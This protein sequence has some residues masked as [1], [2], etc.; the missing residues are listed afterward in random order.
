MKTQPET[1]TYTKVVSIV[2][3]DGKAI[4]E[5][6]VMRETTDGD[7]GVVIRIV[8]AGDIGSPILSNVGDLAIS[9]KPGTTRIT[10]RYD[11]WKH[12][13][14]DDQT[15]SERYLSWMNRDFDYDEGQ[16]ISRDTA[17]AIDGI[18]SLLP[19]DIVDWEYGPWPDRLEDALRFL[20]NHLNK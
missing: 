13:P 16:P 14:H 8:R 2:D 18:M 15:Y 10:N 3:V 4:R 1:V 9:T 5:G 20:V 7:R 12:I 17:L 6:S 19:T 11:S